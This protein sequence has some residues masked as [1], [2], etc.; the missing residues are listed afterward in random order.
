MVLP[1]LKITPLQQ[2]L[3]SITEHLGEMI[4]NSDERERDMCITNKIK[5]AKNTASLGSRVIGDMNPAEWFSFIDHLGSTSGE[6]P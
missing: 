4:L 6:P 5:R 1:N 2:C 3:G